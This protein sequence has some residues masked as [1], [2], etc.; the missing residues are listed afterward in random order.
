MAFRARHA[1][2]GSPGGE[3]SQMLCNLRESA[4]NAPVHRLS[5]SAEMLPSTLNAIFTGQVLPKWGTAERLLGALNASPR[6][7]ERIR[8][9]WEKA[10]RDWTARRASAAQPLADDKQSAPRRPGTLVIN[11]DGSTIYVGNAVGS[12]GIH[13]PPALIPDLDGHALKPD[14]LTATT[15]D[16]LIELMREFRAWAGHPSSRDLASRSAGEFSHATISK[17]LS[18]QPGGKPPLKLGYVRGFIHACG[19][20]DEDLRRWVTAWRR[21][22]QGKAAPHARHARVIAIKPPAGPE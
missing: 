19:G 10:S 14:P 5:A 16:E 20:D 6:E 9:A 11:G 4:G 7:A 22:D 1:D 8:G 2:G 13:E 18:S 17:L 15:F 12:G 3:F 21:I